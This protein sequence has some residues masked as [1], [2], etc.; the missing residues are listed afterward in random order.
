MPLPVPD[1][2]STTPLPEAP[3]TAGRRAAFVRDPHTQRRFVL[4]LGDGEQLPS[5]LCG[6][7]GNCGGGKGITPSAPCASQQDSSQHQK[8]K[9]PQPRPACVVDKLAAAM[10]RALRID[11]PTAAFYV[12]SAGCDLRAAMDKVCVSNLC[13]CQC[14]GAEVQGLGAA[15]STASHIRS[16]PPGAYAA[17]LLYRLPACSTRRT[18]GGSGRCGTAA[19]RCCE[20]C[21]D[22]SRGPFVHNLH[23]LYTIMIV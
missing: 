3:A 21:A 10:Q 16:I 8:Q 7:G 5:Q 9:Q 22:G 1:A 4:L 11:A 19:G 20:R 17:L 15:S 6:G 23:F 12:S 18:G 14:V 13:V 2:A